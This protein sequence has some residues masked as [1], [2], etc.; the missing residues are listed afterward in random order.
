M[1]FDVA[2]CNVELQSR[3]DQQLA[4]ITERFELI[5]VSL[6]VSIVEDLLLLYSG[7][8]LFKLRA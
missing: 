8:K 7:L 1:Q 3:R 6:S 5:K 2:N 4:E